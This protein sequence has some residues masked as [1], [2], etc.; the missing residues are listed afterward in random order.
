[1]ITSCLSCEQEKPRC[2]PSSFWSLLLYYEISSHKLR[3]LKFFHLTHWCFKF[4]I[5]QNFHSTIVSFYRF[6][7]A[8]YVTSYENKLK[9]LNM[10]RTW[11][12]E[13][14]AGDPCWSPHCVCYQIAGPS[15]CHHPGLPPSEL[16]RYVHKRI[17]Y[18]ISHQSRGDSLHQ[19]YSVFPS[20]KE[21]R[22]K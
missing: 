9:S 7:M 22:F 6:S 20:R 21:S 15:L 2:R 19:A 8:I 1:M 10:R 12:S 17:Q 14:P 4:S 5:Q 3:Y 11:G 18:L 13:A 16:V